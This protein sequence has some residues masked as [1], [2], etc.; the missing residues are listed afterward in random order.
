M[1]IN[2]YFEVKDGEVVETSEYNELTNE[3][4]E[5]LNELIIK[6]DN[7]F[8]QKEPEILKEVLNKLKQFETDVMNRKNEDKIYHDLLEQLKKLTPHAEATKTEAAAFDKLYKEIA[9]KIKNR[10]SVT[11]I[12]KLLKELEKE[13]SALDKVVKDR[14][15]AGVETVPEDLYDYNGNYAD[16]Q[17]PP[18]PK[19][20]TPTQPSTPE[21]S[22]PPTKPVE[23]EEPEEPTSPVDSIEPEEPEES[24]EPEETIEPEGRVY[25]QVIGDFIFFPLP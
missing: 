20:P 15:D 4:Q 9:D 11:E 7:A 5:K 1:I 22:N 10:G 2:K 3:E 12:D 25:S 16:T 21:P 13:K 18:K 24:E 17:I 14:K 19:P 6:R 8:I 23:S